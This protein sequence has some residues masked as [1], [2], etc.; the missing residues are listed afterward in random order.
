MIVTGAVVALV[1]VNVAVVAVAP[2]AERTV[3][4]LSAAAI[5]LFVAFAGR[6]RRSERVMGAD[7][8][9]VAFTNIAFS[10]SLPTW[11]GWKKKIG[12]LALHP[13]VVS[14]S[15]GRTT[16]SVPRPARAEVVRHKFMFWP[17]V[18]VTGSDQSTLCLVPR[19]APAT[20]HGEPM[21]EMEWEAEQL[22]NAIQ[23]S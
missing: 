18:V 19:G 3:R 12:T 9:A 7:G 15:D 13:D 17:M 4:I 10:G 20:K 2:E 23:G 11:R 5:G 21:D 16:L 22:A 6:G 1:V 8:E 14:I